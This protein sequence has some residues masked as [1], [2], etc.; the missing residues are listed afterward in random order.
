MRRFVP[1]FTARSK[2]RIAMNAAKEVMKRSD[3]LTSTPDRT[4]SK[5]W[6]AMNAAREMMTRSESLASTPTTTLSETRIAMN[7]AKE[8]MTRS[9]NLVKTPATTL[10]STLSSTPTRMTRRNPPKG[11]V[12]MRNG[13]PGDG[14]FDKDQTSFY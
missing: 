9:D 2:T 13:E 12:D 10:S 11:E 7:A 4:L 1:G 8:V 5:T 3:N 6:I 14:E